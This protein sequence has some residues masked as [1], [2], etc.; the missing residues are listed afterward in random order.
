MGSPRTVEW[1]PPCTSYWGLGACGFGRDAWN[2]FWAKMVPKSWF[3]LNRFC[4]SFNSTFQ[5]GSLSN[6]FPETSRILMFEGGPENYYKTHALGFS[7]LCKF[8]L[9]WLQRHIVLSPERKNNTKPTCPVKNTIGRAPQKQK[10]DNWWPAAPVPDNDQCRA[11]IFI[12][13]NA[14]YT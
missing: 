1:L 9:K 8:G 12:L 14:L 13:W 2:P 4:L 6:K 5:A 3:A 11:G 10:N 7:S